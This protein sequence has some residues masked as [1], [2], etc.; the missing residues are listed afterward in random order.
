MASLISDHR[1]VHIHWRHCIPC[2]SR[3][4]SKTTTCGNVKDA[5]A[6][7]CY[8]MGVF[9]TASTDMT[10]SRTFIRGGSRI[11][12]MIKCVLL[13]SAQLPTKVVYK[14]WGLNAVCWQQLRECTQTRTHRSSTKT[15]CMCCLCS[16][17]CLREDLLIL[18]SVQWHLKPCLLHNIA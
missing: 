4:R 1:Y 15:H 8:R 14:S 3:I 9:N 17:V 6:S 11:I 2:I 10:Y 16:D 12:M 18:S 13:Y 7:A 5:Y